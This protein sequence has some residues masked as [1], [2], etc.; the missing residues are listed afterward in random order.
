MGLNYQQHPWRC[1]SRCFAIPT[2]KSRTSSPRT[3]TESQNGRTGSPSEGR[4]N[5]S[6]NFAAVMLGFFFVKSRT[7]FLGKLELPV[8]PFTRQKNTFN[9]TC[10]VALLWPRF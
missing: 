6:F 4:D 1:Q 10:I 3:T 2:T 7:G 9:Q 8:P 5:P